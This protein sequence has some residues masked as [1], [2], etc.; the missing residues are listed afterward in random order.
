MEATG[1][2]ADDPRVRVTFEAADL[3][4]AVASVT[5]YRVVDGVE[6]T[7]RS[8]LRA[9]A[10]GGWTGVDWEAPIG[11]V[12]YRAEMFDAAGNDLGSTGSVSAEIPY[13]DADVAFLSDPLDAS[14]TI[15]VVLNSGVDSGQSRPV[16]GT[17]FDLGDR[18]VILAGP[19]QLLTVAVNFETATVEDRAAVNALIDRTGGLVL[20]R[21]APPVPLP[22]LLY[23]WCSDPQPSMSPM[24]SFAVTKWANT[25]KE[26]SEPKSAPAVAA[27]PYAIYEAAFP[28]YGDAEGAYQSYFDA[29]KNPPS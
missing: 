28:T 7:V 24:D 23:C 17:E 2:I 29:Y 22:R 5:V 4:P 6:T 26:V 8:G 3:A 19:R 11:P 27:V 18:K 15:P 16:S 21:S 14:S 1:L 13:T 12:A 25:A 10:A 20:I 9:P